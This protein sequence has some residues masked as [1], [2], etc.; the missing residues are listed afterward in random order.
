LLHSKKKGLKVAIVRL[1]TLSLCSYFP[2]QTLADS[3]EAHYPLSL[4]V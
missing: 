1:L 4:T 3:S 2:L